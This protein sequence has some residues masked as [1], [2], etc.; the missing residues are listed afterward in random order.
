[1]A[2]SVLDSE[3]AI[4]SSFVKKCF[5]NDIELGCSGTLLLTDRNRLVFVAG[6]ILNKKCEAVHYY[7]IRFVTSAR[8]E[9]QP[10]GN[11]LEIHVAWRKPKEQRTFRYE[12][13]NRPEFWVSKL[14]E[15]KQFYEARAT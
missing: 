4:L 9:K 8:A 1:M 10:N 2:T 5:E 14:E 12:G 3:K 15:I 11:A 6:G 7:S 13:V